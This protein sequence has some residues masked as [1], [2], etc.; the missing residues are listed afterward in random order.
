MSPNTN[1]NIS[2]DSCR[3]RLDHD[4]PR[5]QGDTR[6][7]RRPSPIK[8]K[9]IKGPMDVAWVCQASH[10][11]VKALL[12]GIAL[13]HLRGLRH[14][15]TFIVSNL[16][17]QDWG[18]QPDAKRRALRVLEKAGLIRVERRGK[19]SPQVTIIVKN[20]GNGD[21]VIAPAQSE[22]QAAGVKTRATHGDTVAS[23]PVSLQ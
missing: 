2:W 15:D 3:L 6:Q 5:L 10:L 9:F 18:V 23:P 21:P 8:G 13:W 17:L 7:G 11:G 19:R 14:A 4:G 12:V 1:T 20:M 16:M 22:E